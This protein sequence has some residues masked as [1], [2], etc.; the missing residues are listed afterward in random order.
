MSKIV[1]SAVILLVLLVISF[2]YFAKTGIREKSLRNV[3]IPILVDRHFDKYSFE[4]LRNKSFGASEIILGNAIK[5]DADFKS[6]VF[7]FNVDGK[8]VSGLINLPIKP[9]RYPV[10]VMLRGY[11]DKEIYTT[12]IGTSHMAEFLAKSGFITL[13]PD[14]LG[15]GESDNPS[16]ESIEERFQTY[17]TGL[18]LINSLKNLGSVLASNSLGVEADVDKVGIWGHSNGGQIALS[19]LE[20]TGSNLPAVLWAPVSKPFPYSILYYTDDFDD[21]GKMLRKVVSDF[22]RDYDSEKYSVTNYLD[23][24]NSSIQIHQGTEDDA[25][26]VKWSDQLALELKKRDKEVTYFTYLNE[27]HNF[28]KGSWQLIAERSRAFYTNFFKKAD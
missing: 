24:I 8:R 18:T 3:P 1:F 9:G 5:E 16:D 4:A 22:E 27:D 28:S 7:Y 13:A 11:V 25:V 14:F 17:T 21:H 20:I 23:W 12:G 26:P 10:V 19:I 2:F 6:Q 15:Y